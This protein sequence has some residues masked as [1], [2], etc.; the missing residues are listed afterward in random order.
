MKFKYVLKNIFANK[1]NIKYSV[2]ILIIITTILVV[3]IYSCINNKEGKIVINDAQVIQ[4]IGKN[5]VGVYIDGEV[6]N[7]GYIEISKGKNLEYAL[8]KIGGITKDADINNIDLKQIL[9]NGEKIIV[10]KKREFSD[11]EDLEIDNAEMDDVQ[12]FMINI[13]EAGEEELKSLPGIGDVTARRII[14]Y[15]NK[16]RFESIEEIME[17]KGIGDRIYEKIKN[18]ICV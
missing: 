13:N 18:N 5:K 11:V 16:K 10:P 3:S 8:S 4:K 17:V 1:E 2:Y 14:E 6:N 15:R 12:D 7:P 9:K